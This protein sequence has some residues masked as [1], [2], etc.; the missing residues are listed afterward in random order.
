MPNVRRSRPQSAQVPGERGTDFGYPPPDRLVGH[1]EPTFS[2]E[3][4]T[5]P[6][7]DSEPQVQL[8]GVPDDFE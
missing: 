5:I 3:F 2:Q 1:G 8:D 6:I 7:A 4:L